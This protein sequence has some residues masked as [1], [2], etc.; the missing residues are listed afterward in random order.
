M[1][2]SNLFST[3]YQIRVIL[4]DLQILQY[5]YLTGSEKAVRLFARGNIELFLPDNG[6]QTADY[7]VVIISIMQGLKIAIGGKGGVGKTTVCAIWAQLFTKSGFD[8]LVI[9]ADPKFLQDPD[10]LHM[11]CYL[12]AL[13]HLL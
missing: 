10:P 13:V 6:V 1:D 8:V 9:D 4:Y 11:I 3:T 12:Q 7:K 5:K 2:H